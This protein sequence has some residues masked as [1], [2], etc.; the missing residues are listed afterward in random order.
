MA[1]T[2]WD[3]SRA[4]PLRDVQEAAERIGIE[5]TMG[6]IEVGA[7]DG[8]ETVTGEREICAEASPDAQEADMSSVQV[9]VM[10]SATIVA[11]LADVPVSG[12]LS[13]HIRIDANALTRDQATT[14]K[15]LLAGL[16]SKHSELRNGK[17][18]VTSADAIRWLLEQATPA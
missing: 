13:R 12:F 6:D 2:K 9:V 8:H 18:V 10:P 11:P 17:P 14:L 7:P 1:K 3:H 4:T 16:R 15:R 5:D